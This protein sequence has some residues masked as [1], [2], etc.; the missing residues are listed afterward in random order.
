MN[1]NTEKTGEEK[2]N[3]EQARDVGGVVRDL[4]GTR[5][6]K[7]TRQVPSNEEEGDEGEDGDAEDGRDDGENTGKKANMF[8]SL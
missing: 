2:N 5:P 7:E 3:T 1:K 4:R 8:L 6:S